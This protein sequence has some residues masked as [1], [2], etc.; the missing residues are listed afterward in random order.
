MCKVVNYQ[1][2]I[3]NIGIGKVSRLA[4]RRWQCRDAV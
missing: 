4:S 2:N 1:M 3:V